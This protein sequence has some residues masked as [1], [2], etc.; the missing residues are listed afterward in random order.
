MQENVT[1]TD[2]NLGIKSFKRKF[3]REKKSLEKLSYYW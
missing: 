1:T 2:F 3:P